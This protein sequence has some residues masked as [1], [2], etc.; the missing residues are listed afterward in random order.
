MPFKKWKF[1]S[2]TMAG[3]FLSSP[4][5]KN[6]SNNEKTIK[7]T[8]F[9]LLVWKKWCL[10]KGIVK[11]IENYEP[12]RLNTLLELSNAEIKNKH[13]ETSETTIPFHRQWFGHGLNNSLNC[14]AGL[15]TFLRLKDVKISSHIIVLIV[16]G[17]F[18]WTHDLNKLFL[19]LMRALCLC[20]IMISHLV[21][22][23]SILLTR[24]HMIFSCNLE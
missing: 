22:F 23:S 20:L 1:A 15:W 6:S 5:L 21:F 24:N 16:R 7:S 8:A 10:E 14:L 12:T 3:G 13:G 9:W 17:C 2:E 4:Q 18:D 19:H 11:E